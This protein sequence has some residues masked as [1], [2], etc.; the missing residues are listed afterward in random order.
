MSDSTTMN[1]EAI[2]RALEREEQERADTML[3]Q[4]LHQQN[5][6]A[7]SGG[8]GNSGHS[9]T[10]TIVQGQPLNCPGFHDLNEFLVSYAQ[11]VECNACKRT[12]NRDERAYGC[13]ACNYDVC[14]RCY[15]GN[16]GTGTGTGIGS[17]SSLS[18][19][20]QPHL[21]AHPPQHAAIS[22]NDATPSSHMCVVPCVIGSGTPS[23]ICVEMMIDTGAQT[24]VMSL[25]LAKELGLSN[26]INSMYRG[27]ANGVGQA[28]ICGKIR[29]VAVEF[30]GSH[31]EFPMDFMVLDVSERLLLLGLDLMRRYQCIVNLQ[32]E[33]LI[34]GGDG[35]RSEEHTSELQS[36]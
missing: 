26:R 30:T 21:L 36:P 6:G 2:A 24:S 20:N 8:N 1:D 4:R 19:R 13:V 25:A 27:V 28:R 15:L 32:K 3:A 18:N 29:N 23:S 14:R 17:N 22:G 31:V 33:V 11:R 10:P 5:G 9:I 7:S 16:S 34:F 35:G 12:L